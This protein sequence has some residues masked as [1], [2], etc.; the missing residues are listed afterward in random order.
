[1]GDEEAYTEFNPPLIEVRNGIY[2]LARHRDCRA[3]MTFAHELGHLVMHPVAA[4]LRNESGN[5]TAPK[6]K[7]FESA[8]WQAR[9]FGAYFLMPEHIVVQFGSVRE[10]AENCHVSLQAAEIRFKEVGHIRDATAPCVD[11]LIK[12]IDPTRS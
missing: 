6:I 8:E 1:M 12:A 2:S 4:K 9:K 10:L 7:P 3:L 5:K 11:E